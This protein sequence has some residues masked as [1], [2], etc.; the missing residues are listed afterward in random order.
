MED[1]TPLPQGIYLEYKPAGGSLGSLLNLA[2][3]RKNGEG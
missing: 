3:C 1:P 2:S